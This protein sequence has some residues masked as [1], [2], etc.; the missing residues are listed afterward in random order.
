MLAPELNGQRVVTT[1]ALTWNKGN[2]HRNLSSGNT[3]TAFNNISVS[4]T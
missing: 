2:M 4:A 3:S 1:C